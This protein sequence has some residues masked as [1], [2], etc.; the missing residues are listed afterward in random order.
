M[1]EKKRR[2]R[3][4]QSLNDLKR[5]LMETD[6]V[7][8]EV[9]LHVLSF[10]YRSHKRHGPAYIGFDFSVIDNRYNETLLSNSNKN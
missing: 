7:K 5:L 9:C 2:A 4:N 8:K 10:L 3:I 1:M 6:N